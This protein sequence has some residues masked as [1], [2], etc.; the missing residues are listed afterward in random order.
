MLYEWR[1]DA[2]IASAELAL[3]TRHLLAGRRCRP[4]FLEGSVPAKPQR[5]R[6]SVTNH[7]DVKLLAFRCVRVQRVEALQLAGVRKSR[8]PT[9]INT[10]CAEDRDGP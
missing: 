5:Y 9:R 10:L 2:L 6:G 1:V 3:R 4:P 8:R 7:W